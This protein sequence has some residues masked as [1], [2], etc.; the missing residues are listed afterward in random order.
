[1]GLDY[2]A[3][4][5]FLPTWARYSDRSADAKQTGP[6]GKN[7]ALWKSSGSAFPIDHG[8]LTAAPM[9]P[10]LQASYPQIESVVRFAKGNLLVRRGTT[11][12]QEKGT[13]VVDPDP[14]HR[15]GNG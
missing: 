11:K 1:M 6:D 5:V 4:K 13:V 9:G 8:A 15:P 12:F 7:R 10:M 14:V 2:M 3:P